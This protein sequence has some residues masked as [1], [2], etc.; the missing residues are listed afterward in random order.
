MSQARILIIEDEA[1]IRAN[2][3]RLLTLEGYAVTATENGAAGLAAAQAAPPDLVICD[4]L[5]PELDGYGVLAGLRAR[6]ETSA[7]PFI[8]LTA[9]AAKSEREAA[10]ARGASGFFTKPFALQDVVAAVRE[11]LANP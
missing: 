1:H 5:M 2:L 11:R 6:A 3:A 9:S 4:L 10:L 8:L 7:V